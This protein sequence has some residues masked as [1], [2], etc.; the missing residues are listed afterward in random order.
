M[1]KL[2]VVIPLLFGLIGCNFNSKDSEPHEE[3]P[4]VEPAVEEPKEEEPAPVVEPE[5]NNESSE[6]EV[7][8]ENETPTEPETPVEPEPE[9]P[10]D[11]EPEVPAIKSVEDVVADINDALSLYGVALSDK[12]TYWGITLNFSEDGVDYSDTQAA[13][14]VL[15]PVV[16]ALFSFMPDYLELVGAKYFTSEE[17]FWEDGS[18]DTVYY[19]YLEV[20]ELGVDLISYC[21][22]GYLLGQMSVYS[23]A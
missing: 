3:T 7:P 4:V 9:T 10:V 12:G 13:S 18:G 19:A 11:P 5:Q 8:G 17:D 2:L 16:Q 14:D 20:D 22:M 1:K 23:I 15:L 6:P 21:Y